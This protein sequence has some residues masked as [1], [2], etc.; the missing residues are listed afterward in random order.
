MCLMS[1]C[2]HLSVL[3]LQSVRTSEHVYTCP[4]LSGNTLQ[5]QQLPDTN[6]PPLTNINK[7]SQ[8]V[9]PLNQLQEFTASQSYLVNINGGTQ[10][11]PCL[12]L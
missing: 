10:T 9:R 5:T 11:S 2:G 3:V 4:L 12:L 6:S 1:T 7:D 8:S